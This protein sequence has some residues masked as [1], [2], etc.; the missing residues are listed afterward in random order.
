VRNLL[1][2]DI[3]VVLARCPTVRPVHVNAWHARLG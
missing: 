1:K 3:T 2:F